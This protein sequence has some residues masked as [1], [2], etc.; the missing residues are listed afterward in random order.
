MKRLIAILLSCCI[1]MTGCTVSDLP[2]DNGTSEISELISTNENTD[3]STEEIIEKPNVMPTVKPTFNDL[4]DT[5]L[6][7]YLEDDVY[8][9]LVNLFNS[10]DYFVEDVQVQYLSKEYLEELE[11]NS[12]ENIFF[13]YAL[14]DLV[15]A[16]GDAR[17]VFSLGDD[18]QTTIKPFEE[19]D[20]TFDKVIKNVAIGTGVILICV[21]VS[22][23][24]AGAGAPAAVSAVFAAS[25]KGSAIM[26]LSGAAFGGLTNG[27]VEYVQTNDIEAA[28]KAAL[29]GASEE[30]KWGAIIG[31]V[32]GGAEEVISLKMPNTR[33]IPT[34]RE[35]EKRALAKYGGKEQVSFLNGKQVPYGTEGATRPDI[36]REIGGKLE[37]IEVKRYDL[38]NNLPQLCQELERQV[39]DRVVNLPA[40]YSQ[41][42]VLNT[43]GR[44][45]SK[46][47]MDNVIQTLQEYLEPIYPN[48]PIEV[49]A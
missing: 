5:E 44:S 32:A 33:E 40:D 6:H 46:T 2:Q 34:P 21:T 41:R 12:K 14:S 20:D 31:A 28:K 38:D 7:R 25:A 11:Y 10:D 30:F 35:A 27:I 43:Q 36:V 18:G 39:G 48:L 26:A 19:Y 9:Q 17:Y 29:L 22:I 16:L 47:F 23:V 49:M 42:V 37:A 1:F 15:D 3:T 8:A 45:Y 24:T 4:S 13:G